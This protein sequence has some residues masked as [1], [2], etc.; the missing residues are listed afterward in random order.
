MFSFSCCTSSL[1][2]FFKIQQSHLATQTNMF[3]GMIFKNPFPSLTFFT[4]DNFLVNDRRVSNSRAH[5]T[6][7][8]MFLLFDIQI[9][10]IKCDYSTVSDCTNCSA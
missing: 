1:L 4:V 2:C 9:V 6:V 3:A 8:F 5:L 10:V 7:A